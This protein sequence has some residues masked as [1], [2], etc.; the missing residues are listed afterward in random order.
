MSNILLFWD[1]SAQKYL[2]RTRQRKR[3]VV[4]VGGRVGAGADADNPMLVAGCQINE[5]D[6]EVGVGC[7]GVVKVEADY[8]A[9]FHGKN[10]LFI[11]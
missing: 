2:D 6:P 10:I 5:V 1:V 9:G 11:K 8:Q 7:K 4:E 3:K